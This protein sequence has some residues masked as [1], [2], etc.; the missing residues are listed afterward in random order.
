M[1][2]Y[3]HTD[4]NYISERIIRAVYIWYFRVFCSNVFHY[5]RLFLGQYGLPDVRLLAHVDEASSN[6]YINPCCNTLSNL[7]PQV[8]QVRLTR[9]LNLGR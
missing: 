9:P 7:A 8:C 6:T 5:I 1:S 2:S 4:E 3:V